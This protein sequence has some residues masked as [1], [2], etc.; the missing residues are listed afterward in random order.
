MDNSSSNLCGV[1][2]AYPKRSDTFLHNSF[3]VTDS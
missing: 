1:K 2:K 3:E